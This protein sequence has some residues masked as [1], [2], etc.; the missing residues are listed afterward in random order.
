MFKIWLATKNRKHARPIN[1]NQSDISTRL[2]TSHFTF[3]SLSFDLDFTLCRLF[4]DYVGYNYKP[5]VSPEI[6][7]TLIPDNERLNKGEKMKIKY[8]NP[9]YQII[10]DSFRAFFALFFYVFL[11]LDDVIGRDIEFETEYVVLVAI[12]LLGTFWCGWACPF[13]NAGYF[14]SKLGKRLFPR[15]QWMPS[16]KLDWTLRNLKYVVLAFFTWIFISKGFSYFGDHSEM[17]FSNPI[18]TVF[19]V[20]KLLPAVLIIP[21]FIPRFFC[22]YLCFQKA[23]YNIMNYLFRLTA[24][25]R[26]EQVCTDCKLC[27]KVCSMNIKISEKNTIYGNDCIGCYDCIT[28]KTCPEKARALSLV[29]ANKKVHLYRFV[30]VAIAIYIMAT[31]LVMYV[32]NVIE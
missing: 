9:S 6:H 5:L 23:A 22:K 4:Y 30:S 13:G 25:K 14:V 8:R 7:M 31:Y 27:D 16:D 10:R 3:F 21:L 15:W 18:S 24:I 28:T 29:V 12:L 2:I 1:N 19:V 17:Y 20:F 26:D 32:F 11:L